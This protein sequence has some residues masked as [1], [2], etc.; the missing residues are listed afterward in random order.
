[1][2]DLSLHILDLVQNSVK[3]GASLVRVRIRDSAKEDVIAVEISDDGCGMDEELL[4]RVTS[5]FT[6]TRTTRKVG[7]GIPL[8]MAN[9]QGSGGA[10]SIDSKPGEGTCV[11]GTFRRSHI[12]RPP[13]GDI[14]GT[15]LTLVLGTPKYPDYIL[16]YE[17]DDTSFTFDTREIRRALDGVPLDLPDV[18]SWMRDYLRE[19]FDQINGGAIL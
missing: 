2:R 1:M 13:M 6:T 8:F 3:A 17:T 9:A 10:F 4:L 11:R 7:L 16:R 12:D 14:Q 5:P 18:V 19:G 15:M